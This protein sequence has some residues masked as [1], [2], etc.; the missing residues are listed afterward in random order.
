MP[1]IALDSRTR[2]GLDAFPNFVE[3]LSS[4]T[5]SLLEIHPA[6]SGLCYY[7][8]NETHARTGL[9]SDPCFCLFHTCG[10]HPRT[11]AACSGDR[12]PGARSGP[13]S[14]RIRLHPNRSL[15]DQLVAPDAP[16]VRR[17]SLQKN[18]S[19]QISFR[20][21]I[22]VG[23]PM[24]WGYGFELFVGWSYRRYQHWNRFHPSQMG[25]CTSLVRV[26]RHKIFYRSFSS[27]AISF[28]HLFCRHWIP[29]QCH[30]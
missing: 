19:A 26:F 6:A 1:Q 4:A 15:Y 12:L 7:R 25:Y 11:R 17:K 27:T 9:R 20:V 2:V 23:C 18:H 24:F 3:K 22:A 13:C 30:S 14:G 16:R 8:K 21:G 10:T 28:R 29:H 5:E